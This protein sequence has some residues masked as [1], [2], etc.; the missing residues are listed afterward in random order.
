MFCKYCG[1]KIEEDARFCPYC[2]ADTS[3][4]VQNHPVSKTPLNAD[5]NILWGLLCFFFPVVGLIIYLCWRDTQPER[6]K[7]CG[8][9]AIVGVCLYA[10]GG[11]LFG[12]LGGIFSGIWHLMFWWL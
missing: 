5:S 2:G 8:I 1:R 7:V 4:E 12:I 3:S 10:F 11:L 9:C 6:A